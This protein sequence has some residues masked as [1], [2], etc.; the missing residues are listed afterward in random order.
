MR[1]NGE[2][3]LVSAFLPFFTI[4]IYKAKDRTAD[5]VAGIITGISLLINGYGFYTFY[6][7]GLSN[8]FH[9][10][11]IQGGFLGE[12]FGLNIDAASA[13]V[14]LVSI[15]T[16]FLLTLYAAGYMGP[17]NK[18]FP[19]K[20]KKGK[21]YAIFGPLIGSSMI[22]IY[23]TNL[24]QFLIFLEIMAIS[25]F[26]LVNFYGSSRAKAIKDFLVLNLGVGLLVIAVVILGGD[27]ELVKMAGVSQYTK[28]IVF[29]LI[30]FSSFAMSSQFF[31]YSWLPD[32]SDGP[33]P[34][35][36]YIHAASVVPLGSF[37]LFR[38]I[39]YMNPGADEFWLL[40]GLTVALIILMMVYYPIQKD[41]RKLIAYSTIS[42]TGISY[43]TLAYALTGYPAGLQISVYQIVN[44]AFVKALAFMS[45]GGF[46]YA[47]GTTNFE[48][49]KDI[50]HRVP[51]SSVSWFMSFFGLAGVLPLGIFLNKVFSVTVTHH[52]I[53]AASWLFPGAILL[54][55]AVFLIVVI[56]WFRDMFFGKIRPVA[57]A[58]TSLIMR[59]TMVVLIIIGIIAPWLT[60]DI[61]FKIEFYGG[62]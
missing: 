51:W 38:V 35:T 23:G 47:L 13:L 28:N 16:G 6:T 34:S 18:Q 53:G 33:I 39:Q 27:Q 11:Y 36:A 58:H 43:L 42:Q 48:K 31:F 1:V 56:I 10:S 26:Y 37:M 57:K 59:I 40:G 5:Y 25:M 15:L 20:N 49:I 45:V 24:I 32:T 2:I 44:H 21:F 8:T 3:F 4:L 62:I 50:R 19:I 55:G 46:A 17:L 22:F 7:G 14:G 54:D 60:L 61:I 30:M 9:Y 41:G 29:P 52:A 12:I